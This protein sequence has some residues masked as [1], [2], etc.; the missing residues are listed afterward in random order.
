LLLGA[1]AAAWACQHRGPRGYEGRIIGGAQSFGHRLLGETTD[2]ASGE[3]ES[4][5]IA[6]VGA[7]IAGLS[8][9]WRLERRGEPRF[10][11]F[12]LE[13]KAGGT[14]C[15]GDDAAV[16]Y[17]WA[18]HYLPVPDASNTDL[19]ALLRE[20]GALE[21]SKSGEWAP[22]E[23]ML[24]RAPDERL[25]LDG[26][27]IPGL[28]PRT[29]M[30]PS[31][32]EE[33]RRFQRHVDEWVGFR[34]SVGRRAFALPISKSSPDSPWVKDDTLS[35]AQWLRRENFHSRFLLWWLEYG[36]RD[37]YGCSLDS[38]SAWALMHYHSAR[39][40]SPGAASAPFLTWPEGNGRLV[41]HLEQVAGPR[42]KRQQLVHRVKP[43]E[44]GVELTILRR[45]Y[46]GA[47]SYKLR[48][49]HVILAVPQ[50][51]VKRLWQ[52]LRTSDEKN[53]NAFS[54]AP[55][56]VANVHLNGRPRST[57]FPLSWDN[58]LFGSP[59]LGYVVA[60]HQTLNDDGPTIFTYYFPFTDTVPLE[61][62]QA[63]AHL[64]H[65]QCCDI[66]MSDLSRAHPDLN[67][68]VT[69]IDVWRW[70]HAMIRPTPGLIWGG[71]LAEAQR[72]QGRVHFAHTDLSGVALFEEAHAHGVRAAD[73]ILREGG[74]ASTGLG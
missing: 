37:D 24:V 22:A 63:L 46:G 52:P 58:V 39:V 69:R 11:L 48:A 43:V 72:P 4:I 16:P 57:S 15:Y 10:R 47:P 3:T 71:S 65:A 40:P 19:S 60:T 56:L 36:C 54:Y 45:G 41:K 28:L 61:G 5:E 62:R 32:W 7:G 55:W 59:S 18:A 33:F 26:R 64:D 53:Q 9:A 8:A 29:R 12:E 74:A 49:R 66:V 2:A 68:L 51:I 6:I 35:A 27:W 13:S 21:R 14:S 38:T 23:G 73:A 44:D 17:P 31:D 67:E 34:D 25:F 50:F 20:M 1:P 42:I 70:G 30:Q